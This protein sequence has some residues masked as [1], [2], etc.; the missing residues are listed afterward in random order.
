AVT[1]VWVTGLATDY[2]V[3]WTARDAR[4]LGFRTRAIEDA[5]RGVELKDGDIA[6][7][8]DEMRSLGIEVLQSADL[9]R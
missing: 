9:G 1:D 8:F 6:R 4:E 5:C 7:A 3:L 2:C